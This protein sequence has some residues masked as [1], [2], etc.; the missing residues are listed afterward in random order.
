PDPRAAALGLPLVPL[1]RMYAEPARQ[2]IEL[3]GGEVRTNSLA[4][5]VIERGQLRGVD[6]RGARIDATRVI[7]AVPWF[8]LANTIRVDEDASAD[9][10]ALTPLLATAAAMRASPIVTVNV[11]FDRPVIDDL[12]VGLPGRVMQWVFDKRRIWTLRDDR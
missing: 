8:A 11:W 5:V 12:F 9:G 2:F 3:H 4:H 1:D 10:S 7:A 6:V